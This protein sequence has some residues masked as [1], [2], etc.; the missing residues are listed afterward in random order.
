MEDVVLGLGAVAV[1]TVVVF[2]YLVVIWWLDRYER[3]PFAVVLFAF[4][5]GGLGGTMLGCGLTMALSIPFEQL[6]TAVYSEILFAVVTAPIAEELTKGLVFVFLL[7]TPYLDNETDGLIYGAAAGLGFAVVENSFY[8]LATASAGPEIFY[9]TLVVR[10]LFTALVH[11]ISTALLGYAIG[12]VRHRKLTPWLW[13][14]PILGLTLAVINHGLWNF[15]AHVSGSEL[16]SEEMAAGAMGLGM[17]F[18]FFMSA[19][20]FIITQI[21]LM[22]EQKIIGEYLQDEASRGT[23]PEEHARIIPSWRTRRKDDWLPPQIPKKEYVEAAT[24]LAFRRYQFDTA[25]RRHQKKHRREIERYRRKV[26]KLRS[27]QVSE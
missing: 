11:A 2:A 7:A 14:W 18:V 26:K 13:L 1:S 12:Y 9:A 25:A 22:R 20:M 21:S 27:R 23:L 4:L 19:A 17:T 15:L 16:L 6:T 24:M 8:F 5:W 10:T 3:E